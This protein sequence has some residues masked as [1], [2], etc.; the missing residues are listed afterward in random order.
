MN[1]CLI[2]YLSTNRFYFYLTFDISYAIFTFSLVTTIHHGCLLGYL[3]QRRSITFLFHSCRL[4]KAIC[5]PSGQL[6]YAAGTPQRV[7]S[8]LV[9]ARSLFA[10]F[11]S[12]LNSKDV[13]IDS[14]L[15]EKKKREKVTNDITIIF[16]S[17]IAFFVSL[18]PLVLI[19]F[20]YFIVP[21]FPVFTCSVLQ[22][23]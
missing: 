3:Q 7:C 2:S 5:V 11:I 9:A 15:L 12:G 20:V 1:S 23:V 6:R 16:I 17:S 19:I 13:W 8:Q 18:F 21:F 22:S 10:E 14:S 4:P